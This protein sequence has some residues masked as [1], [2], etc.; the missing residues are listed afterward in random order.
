MTNRLIIGL[1]PFCFLFLCLLGARLDAQTDQQN[2]E[3]QDVPLW[4]MHDVSLSDDGTWYALSYFLQTDDKLEETDTSGGDE[5]VELEETDADESS[6]NPEDEDEQ[7]KQKKLELYGEDSPTDVL[8]I[9]Q[10]NGSKEYRVERGEMPLFSQDSQW[11]AYVVPEEEDS[12][13]DGFGGEEFGGEDF[14]GDGFGGEMSGLRTASIELINLNTDE[15]Y[16]WEISSMDVTMAFQ[17]P[18]E[19][20]VFTIQTESGLLLLHLVDLTEHYVGNVTEFHF[21]KNGATLIYTIDSENK[22]GNGIYAYDC[23]SRKTRTLISGHDSFSAVSVHDNNEILAAF[24]VEKADESDEDAVDQVQLVVIRDF[25]TDHPTVEV[26]RVDDWEGMPESKCVVTAGYYEFET[27][28]EWSKDAQL[29][30]FGLKDIEEELAEDEESIDASSEEVNAPSEEVSTAHPMEAD[31]T[32]DVW[33][34]KD[35]HL[36][37]QQM[38]RAEWDEGTTYQ[39]AFNWS[40]KKLVVLSDEDLN[41]TDRTENDRW[42]VAVDESPYI[43][44]WDIERSDIY[45]IDLLTGERT[46]ILE[47]ADSSLELF[48]ME[49]QAVYWKEG[50]HW[51]YDFDTNEHRNLTSNAPVSFVDQS[52]DYYG[53]QV[54]HGLE[55]FL[56]GGKAIVLNSEY[57]LWVQPLNGEPATCLTQGQGKENEIRFQIALPDQ[58]DPDL[59]PEEQYIDLS[60]PVVLRGFG[61]KTKDS[62]YFS[63]NG[64]RLESLHFGPFSAR[65]LRKAKHA[66]IVLFTQGTY[67]QFPETYL[68]DLSF[69]APRKLTNTNPQQQRYRWGQRILINYTNNDGVEL[70]ATLSIPDGYQQGARLPMIVSAYEKLSDELHWYVSPDI[71]AAEVSEMMY[72]SDGYLFLRPDIHFRKRTS[73]SDMH[74]CIDAAIQRVIDLGYVDEKRIGFIGHSFGGHAAMYISTQPNR[75]AAISGGA[76]VSNLIQGFNVDIVSDGTNE[77]DYYITGQGRI[78]TSPAED[79]ALFIDQSPVFHAQNMNTPLLLYHGTADNVVLWEH[80]FGFYNLLRYLKKPV[81]LLSYRGEGHGIGELENRKDLHLRHKEFFGHYLKGEPAPK[82]ITEGVEFEESDGE[83]ASEEEVRT[84]PWK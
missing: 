22:I 79:L 58:M 48:P 67:T 77:Q 73:H 2:I 69:M 29:L 54:S 14:S 60:Q 23:E 46:L 33:H 9:R 12:N 6:A 18:K 61:K 35:E 21:A 53:S 52:Y 26:Q 13:D 31:G 63:L 50:H 64:D 37:S 55:G 38:L 44:D 51:L 74:E 68:S 59:E 39:V 20:N 30:F 25:Q 66:N 7:R 43:S 8:I 45:R 72:V 36:Q 15:K 5:A 78:A 75:F 65:D 42:A 40:T 16:T 4:R 1:A 56:A 41:I 57:D 82:W 32:V 19:A 17:F 27:M 83:E 11:V 62:G 76:G 71:P 3:P 81:I 47:R 10:T 49:S 70:Q 84:V 24:Q 80:S 28:L 34:W